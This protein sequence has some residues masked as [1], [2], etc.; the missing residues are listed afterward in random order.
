MSPTRKEIIQDKA[1]E[2]LDANPKGL[3]YSEL[4]AQIA[5]ALPDIPLFS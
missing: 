5:E 3:R 4:V 2:I 1:V